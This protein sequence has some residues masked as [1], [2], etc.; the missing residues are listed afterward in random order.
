MVWQIYF[1]GFYYEG[2]HAQQ[3]IGDSLLSGSSSSSR[4]IAA[5]RS[6]PHLWSSPATRDEGGGLS[7]LN[8]LNDLHQ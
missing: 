4:S 3:R 1:D 6:N 7:V 8:G 2:I 5:L